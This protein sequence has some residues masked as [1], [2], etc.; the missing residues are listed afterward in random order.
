MPVPLDKTGGISV[1]TQTLSRKIWVTQ[2][3]ACVPYDPCVGN[4]LTNFIL[5]GHD[6]HPIIHVIEPFSAMYAP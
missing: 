4:S 1:L 5:A 2:A 6:A 3:F